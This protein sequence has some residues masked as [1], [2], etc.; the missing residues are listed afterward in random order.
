VSEAVAAPRPRGLE[1]SDPAFWTVHQGDARDLG[2]LLQRAARAAGSDGKP[3]LQTTI[4]SPPY[5]TLVDYGSD[6]QIGFGQSYE[7]YLA[8]CK[9]IFAS[10]HQWTLD[11]GSMWVVADSLL[12]RRHKNGSPS[13]LIPLPFELAAQAESVGWTLREVVVWR[14]DRTRPWSHHG[15]LRN[16]F[17]YVLFFVKSNSFTFNVDRLRDTGNLKSWWVKYPERHN[18]WGMAPDNVWEIPIPVQGSWNDSAFRHACPFPP[19]LVRRMVALSSDEGD[20]VFDPFAGSGAVVK[21]AIQEGRRGLGIELNPE[22]VSLFREGAPAVRREKSE[23]KPVSLMTQRLLELRMLKYPKELAKQV[24]RGGFTTSHVRAVLMEVESV[25][26]KPARTGY[27]KINCSVVVADELSEIESARLSKLLSD[28]VGKAPLSKYGLEV[29]CSIVSVAEAGAKFEDSDV[30]IYTRGRTWHADTTLAGGRLEGWI[31]EA[32]TP[33]IVPIISPL[34]VQ[35][36]L[37]ESL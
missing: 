34:H 17:E 4:T 15:K 9:S 27:G 7:D 35:Q 1:A 2:T 31:R 5:A 24:L 32:G 10:V 18:P 22:Y 23:L 30:S 3:F 8:S 16:G 11:T 12:E 13:R 29:H 26:Y 36:S 14:K 33:T 20:V 28:L 37:E 21:G 19:E 6:N 25:N